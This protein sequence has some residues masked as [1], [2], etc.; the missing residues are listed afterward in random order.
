MIHVMLLL[1]PDPTVRACAYAH[2]VY[3]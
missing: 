1:L 2:R 3:T